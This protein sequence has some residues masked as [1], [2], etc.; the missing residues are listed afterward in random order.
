VIVLTKAGAGWFHLYSGKTGGV[1][2]R[3]GLRKKN[4]A[5]I[6][7]HWNQLSDADFMQKCSMEVCD[8]FNAYYLEKI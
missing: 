3:H 1:I 5:K 6:L 7:L 4:R 2:D 8:G